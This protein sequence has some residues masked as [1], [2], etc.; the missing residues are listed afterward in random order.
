MVTGRTQTF[1]MPVLD[2]LKA[3]SFTAL[4]IDYYVFYKSSYFRNLMSQGEQTRLPVTFT[5]INVDTERQ[6]REARKGQWA[7]TEGT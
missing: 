4:S 2:L 3:F 6:P 7:R 1:L 5:G